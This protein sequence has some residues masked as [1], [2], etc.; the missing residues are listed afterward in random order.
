MRAPVVVLAAFVVSCGGDENPVEPEVLLPTQLTITSISVT[1]VS[2]PYGDYVRTQG[3][4]RNS[5]QLAITD[6]GVV[7][8]VYDG[9]GE[10]IGTDQDVCSPPQIGPNS[11]AAFRNSIPVSEPYAYGDVQL[12][13]ITPQCNQGSGLKHSQ[14]ITWQAGG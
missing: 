12:L 14:T 9:T 4:V 8:V 10:V 2:E 5:S 6:L 11:T 1:G 13:D 7:S 3:T